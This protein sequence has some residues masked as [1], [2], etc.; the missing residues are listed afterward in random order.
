MV[1]KGLAIMKPR[2][3]I[4]PLGQTP[5][6]DWLDPIQEIVGNRIEVIQHGCLDG[7]SHEEILELDQRPDDHMLFTAL[8]AAGG[9]RVGFA[10]RHVL[11]R[12]QDNLD[13]VTAKGASMVAVCC[14]EKWPESYDFDGH[15]IEVFSVM[16]DLVTGMSYRGRGVVFYHV[17]GQQQATVDRWA[18]VEG[19]DF[20][21]LE[22][23]RTDLE[24]EEIMQLLEKAGYTYAVLDCFG[25]SLDLKDQIQH[26]LGLPVYLPLT[27]L[28]NAVRAAYGA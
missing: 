8:P 28:A 21:Y 22:D 6:N 15:W 26:R 25:F 3:C 10:K 13:V 23:G 2:L 18:D 20:V 17:A 7:L 19:L 1:T 5:R 9:K 14:S 12:M 4:M 27:S 24:H 11:D 16:H